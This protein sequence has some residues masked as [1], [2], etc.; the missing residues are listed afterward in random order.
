[1]PNIPAEFRD[2]VGFSSEEPDVSDPADLFEKFLASAQ[3]AGAV[4]GLPAYK[5]VEGL[6]ESSAERNERFATRFSKTHTAEDWDEEV[7]EPESGATLSKRQSDG[8]KA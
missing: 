1:M 6:S 5:L 2:V 3:L 4:G 8:V 7:P